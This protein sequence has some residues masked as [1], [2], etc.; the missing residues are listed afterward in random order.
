VGGLSWLII[1]PG[2]CECGDKPWGYKK[3]TFSGFSISLRP[4]KKC[5]VLKLFLSYIRVFD[6]D[7][8]VTGFRTTGG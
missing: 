7:V 6:D 8:P 2:R 1:V 4:S 3:K 5:V